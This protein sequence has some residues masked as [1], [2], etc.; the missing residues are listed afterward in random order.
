MSE[1]KV[2]MKEWEMMFYH[3]K[4]LFSCQTSILAILW[5]KNNE[6]EDFP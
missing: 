5:H 3:C 4:S 2:H 6:N 1:G